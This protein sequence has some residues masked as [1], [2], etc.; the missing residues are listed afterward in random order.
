MKVIGLQQVKRILQLS[1]MNAIPF[2]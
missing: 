2:H 1:F